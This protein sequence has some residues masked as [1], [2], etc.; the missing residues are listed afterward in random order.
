MAMEVHMTFMEKLNTKW[1]SGKFVCVGLDP[2][3]Q[4]IPLN[5]N[6]AGEGELFRRFLREI[7]DATKDIAAAYK[8]NTAFFEAAQGGIFALESTCDY[9][10]RVCNVPII[11]DFKRGDTG[12]TNIGNAK[13]AF[14][15]CGAD[16]VTVHPYLG[17]EAMEPF[18]KRADKGV[19]V[20]CRTSNTGAGEF[21]DLELK[22]GRTLYQQVAYNVVTE[23]NSNCNCGLVTG[24]TY[25]ADIAK[26][27]DI[28]PNLP[29]LLPGIG[30]QQGD[31]P[32]SVTAA[33][34][35]KGGF[36]VNSSGDIN[37]AKYEPGESWTEASRRA[38]KTL[39]NQIHDC[40]HQ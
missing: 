32:A 39:H 29:L 6:S 12:N 34:T 30:R 35:R 7:V 19:F 38:A 33:R 11:L 40:L 16:A 15:I 8:P 26:V 4:K 20:L 25:P 3:V 5:M 37:Y 36:L 18:L 14:D 17:R 10:R 23:W 13:F 22:N 31:L 24:A 21:Q 28:A 27:R 9:I 2:D 1:A